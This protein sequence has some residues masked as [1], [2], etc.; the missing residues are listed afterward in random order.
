M[1]LNRI[2][3][4]LVFLPL[5]STMTRT[6]Y[7]IRHAESV[8]NSMI[9]DFKTIVGIF[10][11]PPETPRPSILPLYKILWVPGLID[12][13]LSDRGVRQTEALQT[14]C[15]DYNNGVRRGRGGERRVERSD[16]NTLRSATIC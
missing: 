15:R 9:H 13:K 10:P 5:V 1:H 4:L 6:L 2:L 14:F 7:L 3:A 16:S 12:C 11:R 8:E